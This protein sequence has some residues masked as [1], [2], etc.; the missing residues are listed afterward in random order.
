LRRLRPLLAAAL[1]ALAPTALAVEPHPAGAEIRLERAEASVLTYRV[2]LPVDWAARWN[3]LPGVAVVSGPLGKGYPSIA[4]SFEIP[5]GARASLESLTLEV[6]G[7]AG[8]LPAARPL[9][10]TGDDEMLE[11]PGRVAPAARIAPERDAAILEDQGMLGGRGFARVRLFPI[12]AGPH[13]GLLFRRAFL[14]R[15]HL[16]LPKQPFVR[17][18]TALDRVAEEVLVPY[19]GPVLEPASRIEAAATG[20]P[21][22]APTRVRIEVNQT[23]IHRILGSDLQAAGVSLAAIDPATLAM[24]SRGGSIAL[25]VIGDGDGDIDPE[26]EI[27][28]YGVPMVGIYTRTNVYWL[29]WGG[30]A[31]PRM[32]ARSAAP[33][34]GATVPGSFPWTARA[35]SQAIYTSNPPSAALDHWWWDRL[36]PA[37]TS[38]AHALDLPGL[39]AA[40]HTVALRVGVQGRST[41]G[42]NPD[43]HTR[44]EV[45]GVQVDDQT[46]DGQIPFVHAPAVASSRFVPTS[47]S[48]NLVLPGDTGAVSD[49]IYTDFY[50]ADYRRS[51]TAQAN[52][53]EFLGE[54][55]GTFEYRPSGYTSSA[56][57]AFDVTAAALPVQLTGFTVTGV[58]PFTANVQDTPA[59]I[60]RYVVTASSARLTP[61]AVTL[62]QPFDLLATTNGA[63]YL[64][65]APPEFAAAVEPL[66]A[67]R[68]GQGMRAQ[69]VSTKDIY[70]L[71]SDGIF[72]PNAITDFLAYAYASWQAPAP[73]FVVLAGDGSVDYQNYTG[74]GLRNHVPAILVNTDTF[75]E[76]PSDNTYAMVSGAD[77]LPD[78][79]IGRLPVTTAAEA[80]AM[81]SKIIANDMAPPLAGL[82]SQAVF[83][84]DDDD[85]AFQVVLDSRIDDFLPPSI[86][87][88]RVYLSTASNGVAERAA[89]LAGINAGSLMATYLGHG[90]IDSWASEQLL[91]ITDIATLTNSNR[92]PFIAALNCINGYYAD[93]RAAD[94][95]AGDLRYSLMEEAV[96]YGDRGAIAAW[97]PA[98]LSAIGDYDTISYQLFAN[99]FDLREPRIG[100]AAVD[101]LITSISLYGVDAENAK[102]LTF[103]GD[104]ATLFALDT[105]A[106]AVVDG[107]DNCPSVANP[108]QENFDGD[109]QGDACD[110]DDDNDARPDAS[111]CAPLNATAFALPAEADGLVVTGGLSATISWGSQGPTAGS[112]TVYDVV[113]GAISSLKTSLITAATCFASNTASTSVAHGVDPPAGGG[114]I[115]VLAQNACG[116]GGYGSTTA[117]SPRVNAACP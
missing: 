83:V 113:V 115:Q 110:L 96:R 100:R 52:R 13:E 95:T 76:T 69:V 60:R 97:A 98:A 85:V 26:D 10:P 48:I 31:G 11:P 117:G 106:D 37:P 43:H 57:E 19:P 103:F 22:A 38:V 59:G 82:N 33:A 16:E 108:G 94:P 80:T 78:L 25:R 102:E 109:A 84:A 73:S 39:S 65:V 23:G 46:W 21:E 54:G 15:L 90:A 41:S 49:L 61:L 7:T 2:S 64:I 81:V 91:R 105:D 45:N 93:F 42:V 35:E 56:L 14:L 9:G 68:A 74:N 66:R 34:G 8:S 58:N 111:D 104:P 5:G 47:N 89:L 79:Y 4:I 24:T 17:S 101:G 28:F 20:V 63:D 51:Y 53:L 36:S 112:G 18:A 1:A 67:H 77:T 99:L 12:V 40:A 29:S 87:A 55:P 70:D 6:R 62:S 27:E 32:T 50:E 86:A 71:F 3:D 44:V 92:Q 75:G 107:V 116:N 30:V 72:D 114:Y 88:N